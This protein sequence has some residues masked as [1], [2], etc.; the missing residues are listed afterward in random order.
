MDMS[1]PKVVFAD[2]CF[3]QFEGT[4]QE[5]DDLVAE[6]NRLVSTG[7]IFQHATPLTVD[8]LDSDQLVVLAE[9][10]LSESELLELHEQGMPESNSTRRLQ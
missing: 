7:E 3:D 1:T 2:G 8:D 9:A 10:L 5:L 4:Q 6:I